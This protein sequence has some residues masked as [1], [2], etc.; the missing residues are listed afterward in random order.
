MLKS[1]SKSSSKWNRV[2]DYD[3]KIIFWCNITWEENKLILISLL[4]AGETKRH[5]QYNFLKNWVSLG[6]WANQGPVNE[7]GNNIQN[8]IIFKMGERCD[9]I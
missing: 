1:S 8:T 5:I 7:A 4:G 2:C 9:N 3:D 6:E